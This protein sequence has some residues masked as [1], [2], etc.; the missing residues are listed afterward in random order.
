MSSRFIK[1]AN[2]YNLKV[3]VQLKKIYSLWANYNSNYG[4]NKQFFEK[5]YY[6]IKTIM[7]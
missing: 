5:S 4:N 7:Y 3:S 1:P 2:S 6:T